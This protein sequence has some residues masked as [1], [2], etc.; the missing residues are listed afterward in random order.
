MTTTD[1]ASA[2]R[3][4]LEARRIKNTTT[5]L[6]RI[7][8]MLDEDL[9]ARVEQYGRQCAALEDRIDDLREAAAVAEGEDPETDRRAS[10]HDLSP[11][12]AEVGHLE[13]ELATAREALTAVVDEA[14]EAQ[15]TLLFRRASA[16]E[17]EQ[18]IRKHGGASLK[19]DSPAERDFLNSLTDRCFVAVEMPDGSRES[20]QWAEFVESAQLS[21]GELAPIRAL[22]FA[23]NARGGNSVPFSSASSRKI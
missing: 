1:S 10:G 5:G 20:I 6:Q 23:N 9:A 18:L 15:I 13:E 17:Y 16:D 2:L 22:V 8:F 14:R 11:V 21:M 4:K 7:P 12:A 3:D 19:D